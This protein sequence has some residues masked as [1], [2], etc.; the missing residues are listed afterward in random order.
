VAVLL[1]HIEA[2]HPHSFVVIP[3]RVGEPNLRRKEEKKRKKK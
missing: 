1:P 3:K 2:H